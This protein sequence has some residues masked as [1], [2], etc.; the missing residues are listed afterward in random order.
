MQHILPPEGIGLSGIHTLLF[1]LMSCAPTLIKLFINSLSLSPIS[2]GN[3]EC[4]HWRARCINQYYLLDHLALTTRIL[5]I[6]AVLRH[7]P[8]TFQDDGKIWCSRHET[9]ISVKDMYIACNMQTRHQTFSL[10]HL[11]LLSRLSLCDF[12]SS[13]SS[14]KLPSKE[15]NMS[16]AHCNLF[17]ARRAESHGSDEN[18]MKTI[19][20]RQKSHR[21][22]HTREAA[23]HL[24]VSCSC[25]Y[26]DELDSSS[27]ISVD[28]SMGRVKRNEFDLQMAG[29]RL[30]QVASVSLLHTLHTSS[31]TF[32]SVKALIRCNFTW[33]AA[34]SCDFV[35]IGRRERE[36]VFMAL[37]AGPLLPRR[38]VELSIWLFN[39]SFIMNSE[40]SRAVNQH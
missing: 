5:W 21:F 14:S 11:H 8:F 6:S 31:L 7:E 30:R 36:R 26:F 25:I 20:F 10:H 1:F 17:F 27:S 39:L 23:Q 16:N 40:F 9:R 12:Q 3:E 22:A 18:E 13:F 29:W 19:R 24:C 38:W 2:Y 37:L 35:V 33:K 34:T 4:T 15:R 32:M 28:S